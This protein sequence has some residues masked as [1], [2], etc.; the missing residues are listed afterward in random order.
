MIV[1]AVADV[2]ALVATENVTLEFPAAIL[3]LAGTV[4]DALLLVSATKRP[5][6]GAGAVKVTVPVEEA[7]PVTL[8]GFSDIE[9]SAAGALIVS[10]AVALMPLYVAVMVATVEEEPALV[11]TVKV[12]EELPGLT[13]TV[14][15]TVA[16]ELLDDKLITAKPEVTRLVNLTV[17]VELLP[18]ITAVGLNETDD[19][20]TPGLIES[21]AVLVAPA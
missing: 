5:P 17:P 14:P 15:G 16:E 8:A 7:P 9:D 12:A 20:A 2:T 3:T 6:A 10:C 11:V 18:A 1:A 4:A 13:L 19:S 21:A